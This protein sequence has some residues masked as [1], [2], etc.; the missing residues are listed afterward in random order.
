VA[1]YQETAGSCGTAIGYE[2]LNLDSTTRPL[3]REEH[4]AAIK[5]VFEKAQT[6]GNIVPAKGGAANNLVGESAQRFWRILG[7]PIRHGPESAGEQIVAAQ[8]F[9][10]GQWIG[11]A[12][13]VNRAAFSI[14]DPGSSI[15]LVGEFHHDFQ[16]I[17]TIL[18]FNSVPSVSTA[19][20]PA[21]SNAALARNLKHEAIGIRIGRAIQDEVFER[22]GGGEWTTFSTFMPRARKRRSRRHRKV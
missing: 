11:A 18:A 17:D 1:L 12:F 6:L 21:V 10:P 5:A 7:K 4:Q 9:L 14:R 16:T 19:G 3:E 22:T 15:R 13:L 8:E 2:A 20:A